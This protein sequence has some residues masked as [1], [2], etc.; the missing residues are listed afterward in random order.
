VFD[1]PEFN[2]RLF[3]PRPDR[4]PPPP[5]ARDLFVDVPGARL[6]L[7][8][9]TAATPARAVVLLFHGNGEVVADYDD[10]ADHYAA[11][12]AELVVVD[13]RGY[14]ASTG[15]PTLR[16]AIADA[17]PTLAAVRAATRLPVVV[18][19]RS[20]GS[21]C[22]AELYRQ[23]PAGVVGVILESGASDLAGLVRRRGLP[24]P[25]AFSADDRATFD[26]LPKLAA[27]DLPLLVL[28]GADDE[29]IDPAEAR[30]AHAHA[31]AAH[32]QLVFIP[33]RGHND[34][35]LAPAYWQA[36]ATFLAGLGSP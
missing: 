6:H 24:V 2:A 25:H 13:F 30:A 19:G 23:R 11:A 31:G 7:R 34:L 22:A 16:A 27:G 1:S 29:L 36:L 5:G 33:D 14:G 21:A 8:W 12:G 15:V 28:H 18:M 10:L 4:G 17:A 20:L 35:G 3:F 26:P 32:K 9:H